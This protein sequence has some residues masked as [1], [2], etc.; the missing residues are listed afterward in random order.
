MVCSG[1]L[2]CV[3]NATLYLCFFC[4]DTAT[5]EIYTLS[6]HDALPRARPPRAARPTAAGRSHAPGW[7][8]RPRCSPSGRPRDRVADDVEVAVAP[9]AFEAHPELLHHPPRGDVPP[10]RDP[11]C[12]DDVVGELELR[13][14]PRKGKEAAADEPSATALFECPEAQALRGAARQG[15]Q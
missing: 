10:H 14:F 2:P 12:R 3:L 9:R 8:G 1:R 6:L 5:T 4:N 7:S 15:L 11:R 13:S